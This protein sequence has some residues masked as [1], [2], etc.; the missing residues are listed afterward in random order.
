MQMAG[1][2]GSVQLSDRERFRGFF[3]T[4]STGEYLAEALVEI[5]QTFNWRQLAVI[6]LT[7]DVYTIVCRAW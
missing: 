4:D 3:R 6:S 2:D 5:T 7:V 1:I